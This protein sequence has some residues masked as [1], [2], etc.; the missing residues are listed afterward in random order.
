VRADVERDETGGLN[1]AG[2]VI[3]H[4]PREMA[5][6]TLASSGHTGCACG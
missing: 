4:V 3:L 5:P 1:Q 2:T 6:R